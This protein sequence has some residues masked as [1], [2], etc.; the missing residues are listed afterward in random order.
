[1]DLDIEEER[2]PIIRLHYQNSAQFGCACKR[3]KLPYASMQSA[4]ESIDQQSATVE[5][6]LSLLFFS[7]ASIMLLRLNLQNASLK[8]TYL[9]P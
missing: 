5:E 4:N 1:M 9:F 8:R 3:I 2:M 6:L 7:L